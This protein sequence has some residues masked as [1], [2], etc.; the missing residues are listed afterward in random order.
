MRK[1]FFCPFFQKISSPWTMDHSPFPTT[2]AKSN[3][4]TNTNL[5]FFFSIAIRAGFMIRF[6][7]RNPVSPKLPS[8]KPGF[9]NNTQP[10]CIPTFLQLRGIFHFGEGIVKETRFLKYR[11]G[12]T[13]CFC[14]NT[15]LVFF[16]SLL[17]HA[18]FRIGFHPSNW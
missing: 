3:I 2:A 14:T 9:F 5:V 4:C 13:D 8:Q 18:Y 7:A 10:R 11:F 6:G 17:T 16:F 15:N 12:A 1:I